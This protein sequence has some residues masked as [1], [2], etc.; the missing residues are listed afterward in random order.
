MSSRS[1]LIRSL[2]ATLAMGVLVWLTPAPAAAQDLVTEAE[3]MGMLMERRGIGEERPADYAALTQ[4]EQYEI[5]VSILVRSGL[6]TMLLGMSDT[7]TLTRGY[8]ASFLHDLVE[9]KLDCPASTEAEK[10]QCLVNVGILQN[11]EGPLER[12]EVIAALNHP[13]VLAALRLPPKTEPQG[14]KPY[15]Q[16]LEATFSRPI[17]PITPVTP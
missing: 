7:M 12:P 9:E 8:F 15:R 11:T 13:M 6:S 17:S 10:I 14:V 4:K 1:R 5:D 16:V 2:C 3:F